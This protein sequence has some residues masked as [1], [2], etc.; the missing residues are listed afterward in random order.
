MSIIYA[1]LVFGLIVFIHE[2]G[3]FTAAKLS[4][5]TVESFSIGM[6]PALLKKRFGETLYAIRL[7]PIGGA[8]MMKGENDDPQEA[9]VTGEMPRADAETHNPLD[10]PD[11]GSFQRAKLWQRFCII[12]AGSFMNFVSA[13]LI[14]VILFLPTNG[15]RSTQIDSFFDGFA[16]QGEHMLQPGD[17]IVR[18]NDFHAFIYNDVITALELGRGKPYDI[19]VERNGKKIK[20]ENLSFDKTMTDGTSEQLYF[21]IRFGAQPVTFFGRVGYAFQNSMSFL[22]SAFNS[23]KMLISGEVKTQD[24]MGAVGITAVIS[25][26]AKTSM[27]DMWY[28]VAF[29]SVNLAFVNMLPI[30]A[31]DG[32]KTVFLLLELIR[33]K[34][35]NPKYEGAVQV[36]GLVLILGLF[37]FVT[38]ND[39]SKLITGKFYG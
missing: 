26:R 39:I 6:G 36:V 32:G 19:T 21:G 4:G 31:L 11:R 34:P 13:I 3:H 25:E 12:I 29:L 2:L 28:T 38:Y 23:I 14:L 7:L 1:I 24:M 27:A 35:I 33:G 16:A 22:Q 5:V 37:I 9:L 10:D 20:F 17:K 18:I 15:I 30:P 8:V